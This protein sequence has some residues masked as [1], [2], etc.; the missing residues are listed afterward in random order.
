MQISL[1]AFLSQKSFSLSTEQLCHP[2]SSVYNALCASWPAPCLAARKMGTWAVG[3]SMLRDPE[4]SLTH[5][6]FLQGKAERACTLGPWWGLEHDGQTR[7]PVSTSADLFSVAYGD[8]L[9]IASDNRG[10]AHR[11]MQGFRVEG[12]PVRGLHPVL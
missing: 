2:L 5:L 6:S 12:M 3:H 8:I 10:P 9:L 7:I 11:S 1:Q 4:L